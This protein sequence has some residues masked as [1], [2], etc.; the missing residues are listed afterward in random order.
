[1]QAQG[2]QEEEL[3]PSQEKMAA[4]STEQQEEAWN[5]SSLPKTQRAPN[6]AESCTC[7]HEQK[8]LHKNVFC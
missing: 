3:L 2:E 7:I 5:V 6:S 4:S 8:A 1:M